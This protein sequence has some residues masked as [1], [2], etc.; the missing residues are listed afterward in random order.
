MK[1]L[2]QAGPCFKQEVTNGRQERVKQGEKKRD[3][4]KERERDMKVVQVFK[5]F[6]LF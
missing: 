3:R 2:T 1:K 4:G 6:K 5:I